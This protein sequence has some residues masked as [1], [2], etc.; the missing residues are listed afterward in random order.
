MRRRCSL[1][2]DEA[3]RR[4]RP[5]HPSP[6]SGCGDKGGISVARHSGPM[7]AHRV[8]A[9]VALGARNDSHIISDQGQLAHT[10]EVLP[11][12]LPYRIDSG[13]RLWR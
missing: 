10:E 9:D 7:I 2:A 11:P 1:I 6:P 12:C 8:S 3:R 5:Q 13:K 4:D